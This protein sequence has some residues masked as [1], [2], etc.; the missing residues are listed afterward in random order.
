MIVQNKLVKMRPGFL[1]KDSSESGIS[2][3]SAFLRTT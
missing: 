2:M 1:G 3:K